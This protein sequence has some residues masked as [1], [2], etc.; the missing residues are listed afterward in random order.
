MGGVAFQIFD[1]CYHDPETG[2]PWCHPARPRQFAAVI[3]KLS[4]LAERREALA[5]LEYDWELL[6]QVQEWVRYFWERKRL[7]RRS[8]EL[9]S[10]HG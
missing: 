3:F 9:K 2:K 10:F 8:M 7:Q 6:A 4:T 5:L 1:C